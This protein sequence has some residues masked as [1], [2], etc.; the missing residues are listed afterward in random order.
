[1]TN[2]ES[3]HAFLLR[4]RVYCEHPSCGLTEA[5]TV[6]N[7]NGRDTCLCETHANRLKA[8]RKSDK[9][10]DRKETVN[11]KPTCLELR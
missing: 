7:V 3:Y 2:L 10:F 8:A 5:V 9:V 6:E 1:M 4:N 11:P